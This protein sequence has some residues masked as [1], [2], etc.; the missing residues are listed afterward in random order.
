MS[1]VTSYQLPVTHHQL[2]V[3]NP[4]CVLLFGSGETAP[5]S[6]AVYEAVFRRLPSSPL[7]AVLETPA[8]FQ[9]NS[10]AVAEQVAAFIR[11]HLRNHRPRT[12]VVPAR[13]RNTSFG[14]D[15]PA[16]IA[17][18][19]AADV[20][21]LGPG[22][23]T[24]AV[25]QLRDSLAWQL[26][27]AR[28][29]QGAVLILASAATIAVSAFALPVYE[30][31]KVGAD[32]HWQ[33]G[34]GLLAPY[35]LAPVFVPHWNNREGG[36]GLDTSCCFMGR[37]R[38]AALQALLPPE[39][40]FV[41]IDEHTALLIEPVAGQ[42]QVLGAGH[43][44]LLQGGREEVLA[45]GAAFP[46]SRLGPFHLP[47]PDPAL[48]AALATVAPFRTVGPTPPPAVLE[49][50]TARET[51]R[52]RR[53]WATADALRAQIRAQGWTVR[54]TPAGPEVLPAESQD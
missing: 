17:P 52:Q 13:K 33:P 38:F 8:G 23:P 37:E 2:P 11:H 39:T 4:G 16:I 32:L 34:L 49:L 6:T 5:G 28:Q 26:V 3:T 51:A 10:A 35:G 47:E 9:P 31:Y 48:M 12:M 29:R 42:A 1:P 50:V 30:I 15:D 19:A 24:Y 25:R 7:V 54:D 22:S 45:A 40:L 18:V 14:P 27:Q 43:V 21:F 46:L 53:D 20:L 41:G 36:A 44:T